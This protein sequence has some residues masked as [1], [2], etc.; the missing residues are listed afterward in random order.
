MPHGGLKQ[1]PDRIALRLRALPGSADKGG[2]DATAAL[3]HAASLDSP[4]TKEVHTSLELI[5]ELYNYNH[6]IFNKVRPWIRGSV[7]EVGSGLG[8][9][10]QFLL[11]AERVVGLEPHAESLHEISRRFAEH[12]NISFAPH[13]IQHCPNEDI[14]AGSFD[15]VLCLNVLEHIEDDLIAVSRMRELCLDR[16]RVVMLVPAHMSAYGTMDQ[17]FGHY[18]RYNRRGL[19]A[20]FAEAGLKTTYSF[21]MNALGYFGWLW[22]GRVLRRR[23]ISVSAARTFNRLVPF[24]DAIER[25]VRLPFGQSL[26]M[27]GTPC[28]SPNRAPNASAR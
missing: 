4:A 10:T 9:I 8:N 28:A 13:T 7:C 15:T 18:R 3:P 5:K 16:G 26:V 2:M 20:L 21:Y 24:V 19:R 14:P 22:E 11:N 17:S 1:H 23:R 6:W 25:V 27:I 12:L